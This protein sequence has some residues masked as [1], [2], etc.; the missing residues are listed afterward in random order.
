MKKARLKV[1]PQ[2]EQFG[3][4]EHDFT[5]NG[6]KEL[7]T[8]LLRPGAL[9][10]DMEA[11]VGAWTIA[12]LEIEPNICTYS[13]ESSSYSELKTNLSPYPNARVLPIPS[14]TLDQ[15]CTSQ[16]LQGIDLLRIGAGHRSILEGAKNLLTEKKISNIQFTYHKDFSS[17]KETMQTLSSQNYVLF[18][19]FSHGLIHMSQ[20]KDWLENNQYCNYFAILRS[21][22]SQCEPMT[23]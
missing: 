4:G 14:Q 7:L 3:Y 18:R 15:F 5:T 8:K 10:F 11:K 9:L 6:E 13:F 20:W 16:G 1:I 21:N 19:V 2:T 17:L 12:A 23:F 22:I